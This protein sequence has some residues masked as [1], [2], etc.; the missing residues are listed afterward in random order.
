MVA[1][2][3][4]NTRLSP[5]ASQCAQY[6]ISIRLCQSLRERCLQCG[7]SLIVITSHLFMRSS[8]GF[9]HVGITFLYMFAFNCCECNVACDFL[10]ANV[11]GYV[12]CGYMRMKILV[13]EPTHLL[14]NIFYVFIRLL[15]QVFIRDAPGISEKD[16]NRSKSTKVT[17]VTQYNVLD[18]KITKFGRKQTRC[19]CPTSTT[20]SL[21]CAVGT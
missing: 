11:N 9:I 19:I 6:N 3:K 2:G 12:T 20:G 18:A 10:H 14:V 1:Y 5:R 8:C 13:W 15:S 4:I 21:K 7:H 16:E 17:K